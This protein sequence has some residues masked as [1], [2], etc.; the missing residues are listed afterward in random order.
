M[1]TFIVFVSI[2]A[3]VLYIA[4]PVTHAQ[5]RGQGR[6]PDR[7]VGQAPGH[8]DHGNINRPERPERSEQRQDR[9]AKREDLRENRKEDRQEARFEDRLE[10]NPSLKARL[11]SLLPAGTNL[12]TASSGFRNQGQFI[13]ALHV[14]KNL[15]IPFNDLK[16]RMTGSD[17]MSLGQAIH[18]LRPNMPE[19]QTRDE[20]KRA[21]KQAKETEKTKPTT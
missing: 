2:L 13:A 8:I 9:E 5:G 1:K 15:D 12:K 20:A 6:G 11:E 7:A 4:V 14:S 10:R 21:E 3:V 18:D 17:P 16:A 19:K